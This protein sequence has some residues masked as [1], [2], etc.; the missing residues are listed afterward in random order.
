[1]KYLSKLFYQIHIRSNEIFCP[2]EDVPFE[3]KSIFVCGDLC[4]LPPVRA[5]PV[6]TFNDTETMEGFISTNLWRK[7]RLVELSQLIK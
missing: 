7:S 5:K 4:Q 2:G 3:G 6:F 1:M